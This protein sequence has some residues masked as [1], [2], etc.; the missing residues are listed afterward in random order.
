MARKIFFLF[1]A[2]LLLANIGCNSIRKSVESGNYDKAIDLAVRKLSGKRAKKEEHVKGLELALA[3]ANARDLQIVD[4][5]IAEQNNRNWEKINVYYRTIQRRQAKVIP[6]MPLVAKTGYRANLQLADVAIL[7]R[8]SNRK[9]AE[10]VYENAL[11]LLKKGEQGNRIAARDAYEELK[12][13]KHFNVDL[14]N[15]LDYLAQAK[16]LGT[17]HLLVEMRNQSN[18][19]LP[20]D[21]E[22]RIMHL[23]RNDLDSPWLMY[24]FDKNDRQNYD[25]KV[26]IKMNNIDVSPER[27]VHRDYVEEKEVED[28]WAYV[29]DARGN[30]K[31]DTNG[32]DLKQ[33]K[34]AKIKAF[35]R[36]THLSKA[37]KVGGDIEIYDF[38]SRAILDKDRIM[39]EVFFNHYTASFNGDRRALS[40]ESCRR[41]DNRIMPFPSDFAM[42][43]DAADRL[44]PMFR[45]RLK[46]SRMIL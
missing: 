44:K 37:A 46:G 35:V 21:F 13:L 36:E 20:Q 25:Y 12:R 8:E 6:L 33:K 28:G 3:K 45:E 9:A 43:D 42:L 10:S 29:L 30:V 34:Y 11:S 22:Y 24:H 1:F 16:A 26:V 15:T 7:E 38:N 4:A 17:S 14:P 32:N 23:S 41:I 40:D 27:V 18:V 19:A 5:L 2:T 39:T 31:K